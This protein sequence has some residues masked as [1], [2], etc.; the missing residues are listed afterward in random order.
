MGVGSLEKDGFHPVVV[1]FEGDGDRDFIPNIGEVPGVVVDRFVEDFRIGDGDDTAGELAA[2]HPDGW[3]GILYCRWLA[4][5]HDGRLDEAERDDVAA[6]AAHADAVADTE[7]FSAQNDEVAGKGA[8][9]FLQGKGQA[10]GDQS[11]GGR[12]TDGIVKPDGENPER[13]DEGGK[14]RDALPR[15][16]AR[17]ALRVSA[18][19]EICHPAQEQAQQRDGDDDAESEEKLLP[20]LWV[21]ADKFDS[22]EFHS[23]RENR[24]PRHCRLR[25]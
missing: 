3:V 1:V 4:H 16:K 25:I 11:H 15:P 18:H 6:H 12:E 21:D 23:A 19:D 22:E 17:A 14:E 7:V 24:W 8:H 9:D 5:L 20:V 13:E 10:S 2:F